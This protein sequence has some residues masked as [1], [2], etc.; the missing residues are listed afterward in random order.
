MATKGQYMFVLQAMLNGFT[1]NKSLSYRISTIEVIESVLLAQKFVV[2][3]K[4]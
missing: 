1:R 2:D 4:L 3:M